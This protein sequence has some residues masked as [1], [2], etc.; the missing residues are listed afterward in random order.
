MERGRDWYLKIFYSLRRRRTVIVVR[1]IRRHTRY[2]SDVLNNTK[3][4]VGPKG[5]VARDRRAAVEDRQCWH[6]P[7]RPSNSCL[8][9]ILYNFIIMYVTF[10]SSFLNFFY[11]HIIFIL[12]L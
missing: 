8:Y 9:L 10:N 12:Q 1:F 7:S 5:C 6:L 4:V 11:N 3:T 2:S